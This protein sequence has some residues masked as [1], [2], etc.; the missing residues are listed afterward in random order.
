MQSSLHPSRHHDPI[1]YQKSYNSRLEEYVRRS[2]VGKLTY[3]FPS[4]PSPLGRRHMSSKSPPAPDVTPSDS[5]PPSATLTSTDG[6]VV[7]SVQSGLDTHRP[8]ANRSDSRRDAEPGSSGVD[9]RSPHATKIALLEARTAALEHQLARKEAEHATIVE[10]YEFLLHDRQHSSQPPMDGS[11]RS[12]GESGAR[13]ESHSHHDP[14]S[15][16]A[17]LWRRMTGLL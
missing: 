11:S 16:R 17:G 5:V 14:S 8:N 1:Q 12:G 15:V 3:L 7:S 10:R 13:F 2:A 6:R 9:P 4:P